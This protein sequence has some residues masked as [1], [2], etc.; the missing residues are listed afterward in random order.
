MRLFI[1]HIFQMFFFRYD[2]IIKFCFR[3]SKTRCKSIFYDFDEHFMYKKKRDFFTNDIDNQKNYRHRLIFRLFM[4]IFFDFFSCFFVIRNFWFFFFDL[5][6]IIQMSFFDF[7]NWFSFE[8]LIIQQIFHAFIDVVF[9]KFV[10]EKIV[11]IV[12]VN[13]INFDIAK[14][15]QCFDTTQNVLLNCF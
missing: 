6:R 15:Y 7:K 5:L 12:D 4:F 3:I 14:F 10:F 2:V 13:D 8:F 11:V 9:C 1:V